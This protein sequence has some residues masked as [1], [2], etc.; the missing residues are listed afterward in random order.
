MEI[1]NKIIKYIKNPRL[2]MVYMAS[3][4]VL[5]WL[6][7][8]NYI[9]L[10]YKANFGYELDLETPIT[11]NEKLQ[12]LKINNRKV[13]YIKMVDKFLVKKYV[14]DKIGKQYVIPTL[15]VWDN[16]EDIDFNKLPNR[17]V[18]KCTHD[19]GGLVIC[20]DKKRLNIDKI[21]QKL[22]QSLKREYFS[23]GREWPYKDVKPRIIAEEYIACDGHELQDY[24]IHCFNGVPKIILV[25]SERYSK[26]GLKED[27]F[28][29]EWNHL[30]L[31]RPKYPNSSI[32]PKKPMN[33]NLMLELATVLAED[34]PF[35]RIDFYEVSGR[36][37][38]GEITFFPASGFE[39][40]NS[41]EWDTRLGSWISI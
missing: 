30:D 8:E 6:P 28:D 17:F 21:S 32:T 40:F 37:L 11:F 12:W 15:G 23:W 7:D 31:K 22:R 29:T 4:G 16:F 39:K 41:N 3:K 20:K 24:K 10:L 27:F 2:I 33:L 34:I 36:V 25:C 19:S 26:N 38:F 13:E 35:S 18:L 5:K 14:S 1:K 9:K